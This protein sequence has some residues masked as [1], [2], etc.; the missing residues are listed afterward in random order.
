MEQVVFY[1]M[2]SIFMM[3]KESSIIEA[4][5]WKTSSVLQMSLKSAVI[6]VL[7]FVLACCT[8]VHVTHRT[9]GLSGSPGLKL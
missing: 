1:P 9:L 3:E 7:C 6:D 2:A 5:V 4:Q 8:G